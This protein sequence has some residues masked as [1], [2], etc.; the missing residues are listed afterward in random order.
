MSWCRVW[1]PS[2]P[3]VTWVWS[4]SWQRAVQRAGRDRQSWCSVSC[5][6]AWQNILF[7]LFLQV[8][9]INTTDN[10]LAPVYSC[11][12]AGPETPSLSN[13]TSLT[14]DLWIMETPFHVLASQAFHCAEPGSRHDSCL[15]LFMSLL[16]YE[17]Y[18]QTETAEGSTKTEVNSLESLSHLSFHSFHFKDVAAN[19]DLLFFPSRF[20]CLL[21][22]T[23]V[24]VWSRLWPSLRS[25][26]C[27]S[28]ACALWAMP[29]S[30]HW[31]LILQAA[32]SSR[33]WSLHPVTKGGAKSSRD[34][35]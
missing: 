32:T 23:T 4:S 1:R 21:L 11:F 17:V 7:D 33:L 29:T 8:S 3:R 22:V 15:P 19:F 24:L 25:D 27:S 18:Y 5:M 10:S 14:V 13:K 34:L 26:L 2:W 6:W 30:W 12:T 20:H 35:R 9:Q 31:L 16:T 28:A